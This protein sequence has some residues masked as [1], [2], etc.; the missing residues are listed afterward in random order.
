ILPSQF[1]RIIDGIH[2][3]HNS[4]VHPFTDVHLKPSSLNILRPLK[5]LFLRSPL[6]TKFIYL[7]GMLIVGSAFVHGYSMGFF[8]IVQHPI[9]FSRS[10]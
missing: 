6:T 4:C 1:V 3:H 8:H 2:L 10:P 5:K 7:A 9:V